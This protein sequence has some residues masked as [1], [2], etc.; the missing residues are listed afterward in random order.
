MFSRID[1]VI[2]TQA[3]LPRLRENATFTFAV[4]SVLEEEVFRFRVL[5]QELRD[6]KLTVSTLCLLFQ[7]ENF[8]AT[9]RVIY[10]LLSKIFANNEILWFIYL[11]FWIHKLHLIWD[12][13]RIALIISRIP[14]NH[15]ELSRASPLPLLAPCWW[16]AT[17]P[18]HWSIS[19]ITEISESDIRL[20][21]TLNRHCYEVSEGRDNTERR[22]L[23][24]TLISPDV[25]Q[26]IAPQLSL[27]LNACNPCIQSPKPPILSFEVLRRCV[28][29]V[30]WNKIEYIYSSNSSF[31]LV[32]VPI[33]VDLQ[34]NLTIL[35][36]CILAI[37][38]ARIVQGM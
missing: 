6:F 30:V 37:P 34:F 23:K 9:S 17:M 14:D 15:S 29:H 19:L 25:A 3:D 35:L 33:D 32:H 24:S 12:S 22:L 16:C 13:V 21:S 2:S 5:W 38:S 7:T 10:T 1:V 18:W 28:K 31:N 4:S 27:P 26:I 20:G 11:R 8:L 36:V